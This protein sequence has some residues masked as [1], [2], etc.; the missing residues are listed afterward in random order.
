MKRSAV[1]ERGREVGPGDASCACRL[2]VTL[3]HDPS[4]QNP[5]ADELLNVFDPSSW[6]MDQ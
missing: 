6:A 3:W 2:G 4:P 1:R 5:M